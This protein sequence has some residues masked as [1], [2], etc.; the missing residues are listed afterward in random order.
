MSVDKKWLIKSD[1]KIVGP[2]SMDQLENLLLQRQIALI[3]EVRDMHN[4]WLYIREVAELKALTE[5][6]R[7]EL[8]KK[9]EQT[10]T[11]QTTI[12]NTNTVSQTKT[13]E[14]LE[15]DFTSHASPVFTDVNVDAKDIPFSEIEVKVTEI[16]KKKNIPQFVFS[17][18]PVTRKEVKKRKKQGLFVGMAVA[19][20]LTMSL[21]G[22][23]FYKK[24]SQ[25]K[26]ERAMITK[27]RRL[28]MI[29][30][31]SK[32]VE[33]FQKL[34]EEQQYKVLPD[35]LTLFTK[36]DSDGVINTDNILKNIQT[37]PSLS[38]AQK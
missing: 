19:V 25:D 27:V 22:Y 33:A 10:R 23:Y 32:A 4:R 16:E 3:D 6:V 38:L 18:D 2:Y 13:S 7:L 9:S 35:I 28:V 20:L 29:G 11:Y 21:T 31:D 15:V 36:L 17:D 8:D 14:T 1:N 5:K 26:I 37:N 34:N 12:T 30:A 24:W